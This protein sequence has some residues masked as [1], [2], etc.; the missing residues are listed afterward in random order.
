[1]VW[2]IIIG[3]LV[4]ALSG[5]AFWPHKRGLVDKDLRMERYRSQGR[6]DYYSGGGQ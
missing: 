4:A 1:M 2:I 3:V 5:W 6:G